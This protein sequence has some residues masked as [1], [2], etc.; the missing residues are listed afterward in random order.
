LLGRV[1]AA[2]LAPERVVLEITELVRMPDPAGFARA[3]LPLREAGFRLAID[4][5]GAGFSNL[6][7]LV[8]LGPD[9]V[10]IDRT[11]V[12]GAAS[13]PRRRVFLESIAVLGTRVNCGVIG[14]GVETAEDL[15]TLRACGIPFAQGYA[16]ARPAPL[17]ELARRLPPPEPRLLPTTREEESVGAL[18]VPEEGVAPET[19]VGVLVRLFDAYPQPAAVPVLRGGCALGLVTRQVLFT[20]LGHRY[21]F[22]LWSGRPVMTFVSANAEGFDRLPASA[23]LEEAAEL[24]RRRPAARRFDPLVVET[25]NGRYHGLLPVDVLLGE[26]TRLKVDYALQSNPLTGL[27]GS[28]TL[29]RAVEARIAAGQPL[30]LAWVDVDHFKSYNDRY[31]FTR[32]DEVLTLLAELLRLH[33][34]A[35]PGALVA[36]PGG[37]D[38]AFVMDPERA[39]GRAWLV[40]REFSARVAVLYDPADR[41]AGG[42][43]SVDRRG[44]RRSFGLVSLSIGL[45]SWHG[46]PGVDYRR[47][48]EI[49]A[50]VKAKAKS[51]PGPAVIQNARGLWPPPDP[52]EV[53]LTPTPFEDTPWA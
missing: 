26:M 20:H 17:E 36:H 44:E 2:G 51:L 18:A 9:Y 42:I 25:E 7:I 5:F 39:E 21:G 53:E 22:A 32:G 11:L 13:H 15:A 49:T 12:Q 4:D 34:G 33:V 47:L 45:V 28:L 38:F 6:R 27:P 52:V 8:E 29:A 3:V 48:V 16:L 31:G 43:T 40:A 24:V 41:A 14:E 46:E 10:K 50:E 23:S 19:P 35:E 1:R 30:T 37:D